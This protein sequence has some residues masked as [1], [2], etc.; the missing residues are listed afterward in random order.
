MSATAPWPETDCDEQPPASLVAPILED[1]P[2]LPGWPLSR[3]RR[4]LGRGR[5]PHSLPLV[6][7]DPRLRPLLDW[8]ARNTDP[9]RR[10]GAI[11]AALAA[12][13]LAVRDGA[14]NPSEVA[15]SIG[16]AAR[17]ARPLNSRR[18]G[19]ARVSPSPPAE[20]EWDRRTA[21]TDFSADQ[22]LSEISI[23]LLRHAG[24]DPRHNPVFVS[25]L[26]ACLD[27]AVS[28]WLKGAEPGG[29][30]PEFRSE[31]GRFYGDRLI[32]K[33]G[34]DRNL[35]RLLTGPQP[36]RGRGRQAAW[37]RG[38]TYWTA[39]VWVAGVRGEP[40]PVV[41]PE[42]IAHWRKEIDPVI[43]TPHHD[44]EQ[45]LDSRYATTA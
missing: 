41:P 4:L 42:V 35:L 24:L 23:G 7:T 19:Q 6:L 37:Q 1:P 33:L 30:L 39:S 13:D 29:G 16:L 9:T 31:H 44:L 40:V 20:P 15:E 10:L 45:G 21:P 3:W 2:S 14:I 43:C 12:L 27:V 8:V 18:P 32:V 36:G 28:H 11:A 25:R 5:L 17:T 22:P 34:A 26:T 38:L